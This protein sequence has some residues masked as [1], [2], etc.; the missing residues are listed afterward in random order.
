LAK[1]SSKIRPT[2]MAVSAAKLR[3]GTPSVSRT[4]RLRPDQAHSARR[5]GWRMDV[6]G[7]QCLEASAAAETAATYASLRHN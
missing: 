1:T 2:A 7:N 6:N 4:A 5:C 3:C